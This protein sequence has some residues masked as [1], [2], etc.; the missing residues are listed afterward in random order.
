MKL[1]ITQFLRLP[2]A[3]ALLSTIILLI[4]LFSKTVSL[5][6]SVTE[7]ETKFQTPAKLRVKL[8]F[9]MN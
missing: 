7:R 5:C 8:N 2:V 3:P 4:T 9:Y 6:S 1:L